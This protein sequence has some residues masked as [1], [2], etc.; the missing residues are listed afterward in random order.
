MYEANPLSKLK[1][2]LDYIKGNGLWFDG[3]ILDKYINTNTELWGFIKVLKRF[4]VEIIPSMA[5]LLCCGPVLKNQTYLYLKEELLKRV[6]RYKNLDGIILALHGIMITEDLDDAEGDILEEIREIVGKNTYIVC[7]LDF[8][9]NVTEK[10]VEFANVFVGY[11]TAPHIDQFKVGCRAAEILISL[12]NNK[13]ETYTAMLKLPMLVHGDAMITNKPPLSELMEKIKSMRKIK[14]IISASIFASW[15]ILD[16]REAGPCVLVNSIGDK[17]IAQKKA[18][19]LAKEFWDIREQLLIK[20]IPVTE[21]INKAMKIQGGPVIIVNPADSPSAGA[22]G[23]TTC[24]LEALLNEGIRN[25]ALAIITD[26]EAVKESIKAGVGKEIKLK[27]GGKLDS[28]HSKPIEVKGTVKII[29]DGNYILR[30]PLY[31]G[32]E[33]NMG[34]TVVLKIGGI[35]TVITEK[36]SFTFDPQLFR[37]I[38]IEPKDKKLIVLK[39]GINFRSEYE[40]IAKDIFFVDCPGFSDVDFTK[41]KFKNIRRP[42]FPLDRNVNYL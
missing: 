26:P 24:V 14:N 3:T 28:I 10:M 12:I 34:K 17:K 4:N 7:T 21:A 33:I 29:S 2:D 42:V 30:G 38:G 6:R 36:P 15:S 23:D 16:M 41:L 39:D 1:A 5:N 25:A 11:D 37:N 31:T 20:H 19:F 27:I 8:H 32:T 13:P 9:A 40:K 18:L 35:D 22:P